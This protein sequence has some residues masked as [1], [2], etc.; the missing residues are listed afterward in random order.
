MKL[1]KVL[2]LIAVVVIL[3]IFFTLALIPKTTVRNVPMNFTVGTAL[4]FSGDT[5][6]LGFGTVRPTGVVQKTISLSA[7]KAQTVTVASSGNISEFVS[8]DSEFTLTPGEKLK[9]PVT[10]EVPGN[11]TEGYFEGTLKFVFKD[12]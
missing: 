4:G 6:H 3:T 12:D 8:Y 9:Y 10:L 5:D 1:S 7:E 11:V 2:L